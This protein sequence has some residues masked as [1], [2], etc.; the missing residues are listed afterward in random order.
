MLGCVLRVRGQFSPEEFLRQWPLPG[1]TR[2]EPGILLVVASA[3]GRETLSEQVEDALA[4]LHRH[5]AALSALV[6]WPGVETLWLDF[7]LW[8]RNAPYD[9]ASF[10]PNLLSALGAANVRLT[11]SFYPASDESD[12]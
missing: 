11:V 5:E 12:V 1:V 9:S 3:S 10:P 7:G 6:A 4:F 8:Q 2:C